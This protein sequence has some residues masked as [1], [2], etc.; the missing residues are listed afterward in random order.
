MGPIQRRPPRHSRRLH[1]GL[2]AGPVGV[3]IDGIGAYAISIRVRRL[4]K[5]HPSSPQPLIHPA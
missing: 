5:P 3:V 2:T 1:G 4:N